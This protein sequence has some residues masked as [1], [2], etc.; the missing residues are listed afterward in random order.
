M[1]A[2]EGPEACSEEAAAGSLAVVCQLVVSKEMRR[3]CWGTSA[4][5]TRKSSRKLYALFPL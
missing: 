3:G 1:S 4:L 2:P 5:S